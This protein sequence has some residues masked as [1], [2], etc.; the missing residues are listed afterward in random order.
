V[1]KLDD[2]VAAKDT[3]FDAK[4]FKMFR[5]EEKYLDCDSPGKIGA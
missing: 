1:Q 5:A 4:Q 2:V 3:S